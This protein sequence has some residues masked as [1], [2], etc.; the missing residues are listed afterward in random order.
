MDRCRV[1]WQG[2]FIYV[3]GSKPITDFLE[4]SSVELL[5]SGGV[6]VCVAIPLMSSCYVLPSH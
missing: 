6:K 2:V 5:E 3:A 4:G 1:G